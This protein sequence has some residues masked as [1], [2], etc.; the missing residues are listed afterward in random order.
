[1]RYSQSNVDVVNASSIADGV[2]IDGTRIKL[3]NTESGRIAGGVAIMQGGNSLVND[4][5]GIVRA[6]QTTFGHKFMAIT[7]SSG[8]DTIINKGLIAGYVSLGDG[9]DTFIDRDGVIS[10]EPTSGSMETP[11]DFGD[12][13]D[14]YRV[15]G[16]RYL[17]L[18]ASGGAGYDRVVMANTHY[19]INGRSLREFEEVIFE[20]GGNIQQ[21][22]G[23]QSIVLTGNDF[24]NFLDSSNPFVDLSLSDQSLAL[25]RSF[26][27]SIIGGDGRE[28]FQ[29]GGGSTVLGDV[30]LG[31]GD[32]W[33]TISTLPNTPLGLVDGTADAG[34]GKDTLELRLRAGDDQSFDLTNYVGFEA[35]WSNSS[36][37]EAVTSRVFRAS[38]LTDIRLGQRGTLILSA[39]D[40]P[41][42][43]VSGAFGSVFTLEQDARIAR[44]GAPLDLGWDQRTDLTQADDRLSATLTNRGVITGEVKFYTGD[45]FYDG[46]AGT[47]GGTV[48]GNAGND[49]LLGGAGAE[50]FDGGYGADT[51]SG[52]GGVD[53]LNGG[54]GNDLLVGGDAADLL[55]GG[56][57]ADTFLGTRAELAGDSIID[58]SASDR[59][60]V[61]DATL[62]SFGYTLS[63]EALRLG[64][65][66]T[67]TLSGFRGRLVAS[68]A[69]EGGVALALSPS[70]RL[71]NDF[72]GD[73]RSDV[74]WRETGGAFTN[75]LGR[76]DGGLVNND[77]AAFRSGVPMEWRVAGSGDFDGDGRSDVLWRNDNGQIT[78]WLGRAD[79]SIANNDRIALSAV[80]A[81]WRVAAVDDFN[82]D[83]RADILFR[84]T[85]GRITDWL[86]RVD[87]GF[88][89]NDAA[90][91]SRV[92]LDWQIVGSGDF[93][94]D[95]RAD[96]LWRHQ[97]G[98]ITDWL[99]RADG[100]F[101]NNDEIALSSVPAAWKI[102]GTGDFN[103]DGRTDLLWRNTNGGLSDWL[104]R[105]DGSFANN[106]AAAYTTGVPT[107]WHVADTGDYNGD[108]RFDILW[109][110]GNGSLTT[111]L[112]KNDGGFIDND[113]YA[114]FNVSTNWQVQNDYSIV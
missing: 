98:R 15:E 110:N 18:A 13:N 54:A 114:L 88:T 34:V 64:T 48:Y 94:G 80:E 102:V 77:T 27:R 50:H 14:T 60:V 95:G 42:A 7:G 97:D 4:L 81:S 53:T 111:W 101:S 69:P 38:G 8:S 32:D 16:S 65:G 103:G 56:L 71:S 43:N 91:I 45:D 72:N 2:I 104:G 6:L 100:A 57:G 44:Y 79:G 89:N 83:G 112:G 92:P 105:S 55:T 76:V 25:Q 36:Y 40:L 109:R 5:G 12:G 11:L 106:D 62:G 46:R 3:T 41:L 26:F 49:R 86:G 24:F 1:M 58:F 96:V 33:M 74:F 59:I 84:N 66:E 19:Q 68:G 70:M 21:F 108:G 51:L 31:A 107:S 113:M 87:G 61:S 67:I 28:S 82:G 23:F 17:F 63:G 75:W 20:K 90:A 93:N 73:G 39:S 9:A 22:S 47:A 37:V 78:N 10:V 29:L 85:D 52:G 99:G 30:R 35:L